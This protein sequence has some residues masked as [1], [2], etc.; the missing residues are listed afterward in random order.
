MYQVFLF[1]VLYC[2]RSE[3][4]VHFVDIDG[5]VNLTV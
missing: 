3:V 2:L 5:I 4:V 1:F